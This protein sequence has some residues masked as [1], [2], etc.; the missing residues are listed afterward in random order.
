MYLPQIDDERSTLCNYLDVQLD[1]IRAS[2]YGLDDEQARRTPLRSALSISG[3]VK[4]IVYCM[5]QSLSGAGHHEHDQPFEA[6]TASF[7]PTAEETLDVLLS[8]FD[9][10]RA[11]Y[12]TM[13]REGDVETELPV[14]PMPWFGM[15]EA[16]PAK[17]RY[18]YVHH[19]E[20]FARHAGHAD[21]IREEL[22]GATAGALLAAVEGWPAN[23]YITPW[24]P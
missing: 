16:R 3:I 1:A 7:T 21:I 2:A 13:C 9:D 17:L 11:Q 18:L 6:F 23:D 8:V 24:R 5:K 12:M 4:H 22:D 20:E 15:D 10:V 19:V 14:G